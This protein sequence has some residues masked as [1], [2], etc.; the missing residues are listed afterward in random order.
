MLQRGRVLYSR[1]TDSSA[2]AP[3]CKK[4][5]FNGLQP[6][7]KFQSSG[8]RKT[9]MS[10]STDCRSESTCS[11]CNA[12]RPSSGAPDRNLLDSLRSMH[13]IGCFIVNLEC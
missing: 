13:K 7:R 8:F 6:P 9:F 4:V 3:V 2:S 10:A 5:G 11:S 1:E 12:E